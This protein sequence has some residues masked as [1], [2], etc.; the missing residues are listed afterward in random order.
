MFLRC[1]SR[2]LDLSTPL[3]MGVL[4]VTPDSFSDGGLWREPELAVRRGIEMAEQ[5]AAIIDVGG[6]STRPGATP[7]TVEEEL[8][9]VLPVIERLAKVLA[10]P[11]AIDSRH[12]AVMRAALGVGATFINDVAALRESGA[13]SVAAASDAAVCLM[14]MQGEPRS[15]QQAPE[16]ADVASTVRDFLR[17]RIACCARAGIEEDRLIV[18]PGIGF[19]KRPEHNL[20]LLRDLSAWRLDRPVLL[21]VSRKSLIEALTGRP[22]NQR[23]AGSLALTAAAVLAGASII[24]AHDISETVDAVRVAAALRTKR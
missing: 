17:E 4:N 8:R 1:G 12:A 10:I 23:L 14:H 3:V 5:G 15:M 11:I 22:V 24:R 6:E 9:R 18:D 20:A 16:Y 19:G 7:V 2:T 21:G 13:L